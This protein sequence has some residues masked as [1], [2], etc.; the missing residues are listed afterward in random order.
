MEENTRASSFLFFFPVFPHY[1]LLVS[2]PIAVCYIYIC[3]MTRK[4]PLNS[5]PPTTL[6]Q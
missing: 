4:L 5:P 6:D 2:E 1:H 3:E